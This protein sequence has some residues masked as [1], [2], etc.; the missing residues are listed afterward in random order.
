MGR[1]RGTVT[2]RRWEKGVC[3]GRDEGERRGG[4]EGKGRYGKRG[5]KGEEGAVLEEMRDVE[6]AEGR[7]GEG[8]RRDL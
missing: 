2:R 4:W 7:R 6:G 3:K 5:R 1:E 8:E